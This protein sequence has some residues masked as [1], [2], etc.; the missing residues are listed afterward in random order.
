MIA[1]GELA[2]EKKVP[3]KVVFGCF[4]SFGDMSTRQFSFMIE[5]LKEVESELVSL[6]IPFEVR[7]SRSEGRKAGRRAGTKRQQYISPKVVIISNY[8]L[9]SL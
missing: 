7:G 4:S 3:L 9:S 1:G 8:R 6:K 2:K 5:G